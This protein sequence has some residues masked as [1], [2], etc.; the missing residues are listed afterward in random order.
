[1]KTTTP[2]LLAFLFIFVLLTSSS[3]AC[4]MCMGE[5]DAPIAPA[6][7]ASMGLLLGV[8][9]VVASFFV[10]FIVFLARNDGRDLSTA[11][12]LPQTPR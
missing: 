8:L 10:R 3:L 1:V 12:T 5:A 4:T 6:V 9:V 2:S 7:N 11:E